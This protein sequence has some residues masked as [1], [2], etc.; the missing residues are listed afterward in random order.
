MG[1]AMAGCVWEGGFTD[2]LGQ[3]FWQVGAF[4]VS[5]IMTGALGRLGEK[6]SANPLGS[7]HSELA[8]SQFL[9]A[10]HKG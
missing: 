2:Q 10:T 1:S 6:G 5:P 8:Q 9:G 7:F 4:W 3:R